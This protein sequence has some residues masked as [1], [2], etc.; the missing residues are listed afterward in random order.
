MGILMTFITQLA[1]A[2]EN[3]KLSF[4]DTSTK[5]IL[6][7]QDLVAISEKV[8]YTSNALKEKRDLLEDMLESMNDQ[9]KS[10]SGWDLPSGSNG[11]IK[12]ETGHLTVLHTSL[13]KDW[14]KILREHLRVL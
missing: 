12:S 7:G 1:T 13:L 10:M 2:V 4:S 11:V 6:R 14:E 3:Y 8:V 5:R 9:I